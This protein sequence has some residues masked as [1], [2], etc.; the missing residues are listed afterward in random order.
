MAKNARASC[1]EEPGAGILHAGICEGGAG[2]PA[3]LP[4]RSAPDSRN[5]SFAESCVSPRRNRRTS[6]TDFPAQGT[7]K[8]TSWRWRNTKKRNPD[9]DVESIELDV[10]PLSVPERFRIELRETM[11]LPL[12]V[13]VT[14]HVRIRES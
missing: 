5:D 11:N 10:I 9:R 8:S 14:P 12:S 13:S 7:S 6:S 1:S 3:S 2:Q 4:R